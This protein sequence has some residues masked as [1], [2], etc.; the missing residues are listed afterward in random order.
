MMWK[1]HGESLRLTR[2]L[3]LTRTL[4]YTTYSAIINPSQGGVASY[5]ISLGGG[6]GRRE[7]DFLR[8][9][10][11]STLE[12]RCMAL[13]HSLTQV[14]SARRAEQTT[15]RTCV[16]RRSRHQVIC[17]G[18]VLPQSLCLVPVLASEAACADTMWLGARSGP[19]KSQRRRRHLPS[20]APAVS[21][22]IRVLCVLCAVTLLQT[23]GN[24]R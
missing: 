8:L 6:G 20:A 14:T 12:K 23:V 24:L 3:I 10:S 18:H 19:E 2:T 16:R 4:F 5:L 11:A 13:A 1:A 15:H 7:M 17:R 21:W 9:P 22:Q